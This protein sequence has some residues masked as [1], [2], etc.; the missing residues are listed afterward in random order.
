[1]KCLGS[2]GEPLNEEAWDWFNEHVGERRCRIADTWWQTE[3]GGHCIT[4][5]PCDI[6]QVSTPA[7]AMLPFLGINAVIGEIKMFY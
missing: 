6:T 4:P 3:T 1:M 5:T 2:V 7:H